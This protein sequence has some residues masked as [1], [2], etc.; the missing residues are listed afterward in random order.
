MEIAHDDKYQVVR[1]QWLT[2]HKY[3]TIITITNCI[4][5]HICT[6][7]VV[8]KI[9]FMFYFLKVTVFAIQLKLEIGTCNII[10]DWIAK[11]TTTAKR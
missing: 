8:S 9:N 1:P 4:L 3:R 2:L 11:K 6:C 7:N 10:F 5:G